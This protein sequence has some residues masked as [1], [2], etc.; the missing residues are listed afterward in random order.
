MAV[1]SRLTLEDTKAAQKVKNVSAYSPRTSFVGFWWSVCCW[2]LF[3]AVVRRTL[4]RGKCR[5]SSAHGCADW[6]SHRLWV[7]RC[8]S[9]SEGRRDFRLSCRRCKLSRGIVL[10]HDNARPHI[11]RQM[12]A[13]LREQFHWD[14][15]KHPPYSPDL[16]PPDFFLLPKMKEH[17]A[18][19][20]FA[21]DEDLNGCWLNIQAD[22]WYEEGIHKL[23]PRY[24][25]CL[26]VKWDY[27]KK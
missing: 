24:G 2:K 6:E 15:F 20:R 26:N 13:L 3:R 5:D 8:Y 12:Q 25:K 19:K 14:I 21:N 11:V 27:V 18:G 10:L 9:F 16:A 4:P 17:L 7:A 1:F 22:T 23:V